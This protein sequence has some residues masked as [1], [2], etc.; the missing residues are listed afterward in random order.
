MDAIEGLNEGIAKTVLAILPAGIPE[1]GCASNTNDPFF[2]DRTFRMSGNGIYKGS[3]DILCRLIKG[4]LV[5]K[6]APTNTRLHF[7]ITC[8]VSGLFSGGLRAK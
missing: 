2:I 4:E 5:L 8:S 3:V 7:K 6:Q 1:T